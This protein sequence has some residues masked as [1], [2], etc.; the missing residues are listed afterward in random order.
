MA[1]LTHEQFQQALRLLQDNGYT[2]S[3]AL[4]LKVA[5]LL[6]FPWD[7][8]TTDEWE[9]IHNSSI[10]LYGD[11]PLCRAVSAGIR[12]F[13]VIRNAALLPKPGGSRREA[14]KDLLWG[15]TA[16]DKEDD[17]HNQAVLEAYDRG[18]KAVK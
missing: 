1:E 15:T 13:L 18:R 2:V 10:C 6:Q 16:P 4:M 5:R 12:Q 17:D 7:E 9:S 14:V 11:G 3:G 8:P